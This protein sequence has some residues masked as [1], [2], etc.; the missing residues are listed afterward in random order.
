MLLSY[1]IRDWDWKRDHVHY[2]HEILDALDV[3]KP[4]GTAFTGV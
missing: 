4:L 2:T 1:F 3:C